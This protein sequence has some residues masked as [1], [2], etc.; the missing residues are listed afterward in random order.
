MDYNFHTHTV[1]CGH[2]TG[3]QREYIEK[4]IA[5]GIKRMG[6]SEHIP[7]KHDDGYQ[8]YYRCPV[9]DA[10]KYIFE[11]K[12]LKEEYKDKIEL[13]IGFEAEYTDGFFEDMR[14]KAVEWGAEYF[15]LGQHFLDNDY[16][17]PIWSVNETSD[18]EHLKKYVKRVI[19]GIETGFFTY[20]AHPD[21]INF[22]GNEKI[23]EKE[24]RKIC[25]ASKKHNIP[26]EINFLGIRDNRYYPC[27]R[28]FKL[29]GEEKSPVVFGFDA[30]D[31]QSAG[32][33]SS[34]PKANEIVKK[35]SLNLQNTV[36]LKKL[37]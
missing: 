2:A 23:Y 3:T 15:I 14:K 7:F 13:H 26:L 12:K 27:D 20:V 24:M 6:F 36:N 37:V 9:E 16:P 5:S 18:E 31:T 10:Q 1:L 35:Y 22:K 33:L 17:A 19:Q 4:A 32:D 21:L 8:S 11:T 25:I 30:H 29:A 28:F 34:L